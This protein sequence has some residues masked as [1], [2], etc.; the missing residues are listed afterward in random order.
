MSRDRISSTARSSRTI[1]GCGFLGIELATCLIDLK[2][3]KR[4]INR[5]LIL[6]LQAYSHPLAGNTLQ[7]ESL[8][9]RA[10]RIASFQAVA[11]DLELPTGETRATFT[12]DVRFRGEV[13]SGSLSRVL[14]FSQV[15]GT[16]FHRA[17]P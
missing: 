4:Q 12:R 10:A 2:D 17:V 6:I 14:K 11:L 13:V 15:T 5:V 8:A 9:S 7:A 16:V 1:D 3:S